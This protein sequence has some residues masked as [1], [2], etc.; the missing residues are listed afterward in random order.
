MITRRDFLRIAPAMLFAR[1]GAVRSA[2]ERKSLTIAVG[3]KA[4]LFYLP[5]TLAERLGYFAAE[6][7]ELQ[8][9]DFAGGAKALQAMMGG[10]AEVVS[11]GFDHVLTLR[12]KG[13]KLQSF[14]LQTATPSL[15]LGVAKAKSYRSAADLKGLKIGVTAPGSSTHMF[16]NALL[17]SAGLQSDDVSIIGVG[18]G[19]TAVAAMKAGQIDAI[20]NVEPAIS[21]L[22]R[23]GVMKVVV[24]TMSEKGSRQVFGEVLPVGSLY[25]KEEFIKQNPGTVQ[26]LTNAMV[27]ALLWLQKAAPEDVVKTV[28]VEYLLGDKA[29]YLAA[30]ERS[31]PG[32]SKDGSIPPAG[33]AA[34]YRLLRKFDPAVQSAAELDVAQ[35]YDNRFVLQ[36]LKTVR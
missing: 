30:F 36:A 12:A 28:P 4:A 14:V 6:G 3:G 18:T 34:L 1:S 11:G 2:P 15:A 20:A 29:V 19:P 32:Y 31:R 25:T 16:V 35:A 7:L 23:S 21:I 5:L 9:L 13:Q 8:I 17:N 22:E 10:S 27:R 26:A 33:A 24:E